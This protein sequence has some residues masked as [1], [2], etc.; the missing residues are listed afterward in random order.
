MRRGSV[1]DGS[2]SC[3][4][5]VRF[6]GGLVAIRFL[7]YVGFSKSRIQTDPSF[8]KLSFPKALQKIVATEGYSA[9][10]RG[11]SITCI[12]AIPSHALIFYFYELTSSFLEQF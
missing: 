3:R 4:Y 11:L 2:V 1:L 12:R 5:S 10:Y 6:K 7:I 8:S 9:L